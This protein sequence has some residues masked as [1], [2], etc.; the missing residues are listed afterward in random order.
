MTKYNFLLRLIHRLH[1][2]QNHLHE[3]HK[4]HPAF[5]LCLHLQLK[6]PEWCYSFHIAKGHYFLSLTHIIYYLY[7]LHQKVWRLQPRMHHQFH[8]HQY[9]SGLDYNHLGNYRMCQKFHHYLYLL[10]VNQQDIDPHAV[11]L[12][13]NPSV[14]Y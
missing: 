4:L 8:Y 5:H 14:A 1:L 11:G 3:F 12:H 13:I 2:C 7:A 9:Q 10:L 6:I